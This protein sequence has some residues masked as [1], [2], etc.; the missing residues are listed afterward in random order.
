MEE[1]YK[2]SE[3]W[4]HFSPSSDGKAKC[5]ICG[6]IYSYKGGS[7]SNLKKHI[8]IKHHTFLNKHASSN[9]GASSLKRLKPNDDEDAQSIASTS[10][11]IT[12]LTSVSES[13][14]PLSSKKLKQPSQTSILSHL[15]RPC[16]LRRQQ[17]LNDLI[18]HMI[19]HDLQ[20]ISFVENGG[21]RDLMAGVE[22]SYVIP[23][24]FT[25]TYSFLP[26]KFS[27]KTEKL[28]GLL[29]TA[30][31]V[32]ITT[33]GWTAQ[34]SQ[35]SYLAY[36]VHFITKDWTLYSTLLKCHQ[37]DDS[38]TAQHLKDDLYS[39]VNEWDILEKVFSVTSDN[40]SNIKAAIKLTEWG[41]IGCF[42]HT[43]NLIV[44]S[45]LEI[46][47]V[48]P[49]RKKVKAIVEYF[50]RSTKANTKFKAMQGQMNEGQ[51][52]LKLKNDVAT[53]W[54]STYFMIERFLKVREPLTA[55]IGI[56]QIPVELLTESEWVALK[57]MCCVLKPFEQLTTEMSA[58]QNVTLSKVIVIVKGLLSAV[59]KIE[60]S[61]TSDKIKNLIY[62][63][64]KEIGTRFGSAESNTLMARCAFLDPRFKTKVFDSDYNSNSTKEHIQHEVAKLI[65]SER[66]SEDIIHDHDNDEVNTGEETAAYDDQ[67]LVWEDFDKAVE[68]PKDI[69]SKAAAIIEVRAYLAES[70]IPR[71][72]NPLEW[73]KTRA[74]LYPHLAQLAKK[75]LCIMSTSVPSERVF[76]TAGQLISDRRNR[77][78]GENV[79]M[80]MFLHENE[81]L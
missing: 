38:K 28:K 26:Q 33:D 70:L 1:T 54:N 10:S 32:S 44:Q 61:T 76:S 45:G 8:S 3:I 65:I 66:R 74:F 13:A 7:T 15:N 36:T 29:S 24:R 57:E 49:L 19:V 48:S 60:Q 47:D 25:F 46:S 31:S 50:H 78:T 14:L 39:V 43:I 23:S 20:P 71:K 72:E 58:E 53:R 81:N 75:Y 22:P 64:E 5:N 6:I 11:Q 35:T 9:T 18:L 80:I 51:R 68:T 62:H 4:L 30:S 41:H 56:L 55:T 37:F 69:D 67:N 52:S 17:E 21:F 77:L 27:Q 34:H 16:S 40:A 2:R 12:T 59:H 73:W 63:Y 42:A 79:E